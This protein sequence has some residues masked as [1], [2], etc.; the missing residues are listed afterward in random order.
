[1]RQHWVM[2]YETLSNCFLGVFQDVKSD[3]TRVFVISTM[4]NDLE[5]FLDFLE[6]NIQLDEWHVS[7]NGLGF[8]GQITEYI[9]RNADQLREMFSG[10]IAEWIYGKAQHII[11]VQNTGEFLEFSDKTMQIRQVDVFKLNHWDNPAKRSSLKWIQY[12]MDWENVLE[13]P[14]HHSETITTIQQIDEIITYCI[15]DVL[16]TKKIMTLCKDQIALRQTLTNEYAVDLYS[17][18]EPRISKEL[19]SYFL[20]RKLNWDK[21]DLR[22]MRTNRH[23]IVLKDCILPQI[24]F[25]TPVFQSVLDYFKSKT[26]IETK[27]ALNFSIEH[28]GVKTDYGLGGMHGAANPGIYEAKPGW[29]IMTS[30]VIS[31]YPNLAIKN[32]FTP[33]HLPAKDFLEQYEW[34]FEERKLIPKSDPRNY[35]YK[36]ILNSTYGLSNDAN[37]FLYDPMFTMQITINGQLWLSKLYEMLSIGIPEGIPIMQNTDGLEMMIPSHYKEKY[38]EICREWEEMTKLNLEHDEYTKLILRDVNNYIAVYKNGKTKCKGFFEYKDL[39]LHKNKSFLV[40]PKAVYEYLVNGIKPEDYLEQNQN[41]YDYCGAVKSKGGWNFVERKIENGQYI[42]T[43]LQ[44]INRYYISE[45]GVKIVKVHND[46][47]EIQIEAGRWM[48]T[49]CNDIKPFLNVPFESLDINKQYYLEKIYKEIENVTTQISKSGYVQ[50]V[51]F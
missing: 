14:I 4:Q 20:T 23:E 11:E 8:D 7:F 17:A 3:D 38:F 50:G 35:V 6:H 21:K 45:Q 28:K 34:F 16:S 39:A 33:A 37:S 44:K 19:F 46:S 18:S 9:L 42:T 15:N 47:R 32:G 22:E 49:V 40:I 5:D 51:L 24:E 41:L 2:D 36:I 27:N 12:S 31:Y 43:D 30:D 25:K 48:Q 29:I 13:M 10:D 26:V 1:M